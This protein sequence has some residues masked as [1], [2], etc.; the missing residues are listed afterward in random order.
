[1]TN[2]AEGPSPPIPALVADDDE[3]LRSALVRFL[4][5]RG[6]EANQAAS[7]HDALDWLR[8]HKTSVFLLDISMPGMSGVDVVPNALEIDP[9]LAII[10]LSGVNDA[11]TA[12]RC[13][14]HGAMDYLTKPVEL[15]ELSRAIFRA[16]RRRETQLQS[17]A[18]SGWLRDEVQRRTK[19]VQRERHQQERIALATLE[20]LVN[21][22][23]AK[24]PY[25]R[26]HSARVGALAATIA[27]ELQLTDDEIEQIRIAGRLHDLGMIG[28]R[29]DV[30]NKQGPL[31]DEEREHMKQHVRIG[32][33]ILEPLTHLGPVVDFIR[34]HH[35]H[36]DGSG[37]PDGRKRDEIPLGGRIICSAEVHDALTTS[38]PYQEKMS[39]E[40]ATERMRSLAGSVIDPQVMDALA[41]S[42]SRRRTLVFL[43]EEG[44]PPRN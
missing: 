16:V 19:E 12:A 17:R 24:S 37:Y 30:L 29:E 14:Q 15:T 18:I 32:W 35:E 25:L 34:S 13:M 39:P 27:H 8:Q 33:Q 38:R 21:A 20:A 44:P 1:M 28:I 7:G 2:Q 36:W 3:A 43:D 10:M 40:A 31:T 41:T 9:D 23:E 26:G 11:P 4:T 6:F 22:L 5:G 42:V